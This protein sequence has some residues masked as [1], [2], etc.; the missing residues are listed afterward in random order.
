[1]PPSGEPGKPMSIKSVPFAERFS[2]TAVGV[3]VDYLSANDDLCAELKADVARTKYLAELAEAFAFKSLSSGS[4]A[5]KQA[6]V[7]LNK[8]VQARW[9]QHFKAIA[10]YEKA[11]A[12][13]E[14]GEMIFQGWRTAS[15]NRRQGSP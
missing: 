14:R 7:Q 10:A 12:T 8:E 9:E 1:M 3:V 5:D 4:V 15:S 6:E 11:R 13:R 2:E